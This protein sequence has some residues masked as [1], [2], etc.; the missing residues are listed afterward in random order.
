V[1]QKQQGYNAVTVRL[2]RGDVTAAQFRG[3]AKLAR[4][5]GDGM[6][7][8]TIDQNLL[9]RFVPDD[10]L[11]AL[12]QGLKDL[13]LAEPDAGTIVD[14]TSCPGAES[15]NLAVTASRELASALSAKLSAA[16]SEAAGSADAVAAAKDLHLKISGCPNSCGQHHVA[17]I[18]F[19]GSM[20]RVG[21]RV[22][23][24]YTL[25]L[26]GGID[27]NGAVF[28]RAFAKVPARRTPGALLKLLEL[29]LAERQPGEDALT[30][31]RRVPE[32]TVKGALADLS[33]IDEA[34]ATAE[35]Y[36]DLGDD[37]EFE[38]ATGPGECAT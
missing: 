11:E 29:Y 9:L 33:K 3:V 13:E 8:T 15:C 30:F 26:G 31:F 23:P 37:K 27:G 16:V 14:V 19:H 34:T 10:A 7:R 6:A 32:E 28:G 5:L 36:L 4:Q 21:G 35:D 17:G 12:H 1:P 18:G 2:L 38:V 25:H 24:E 22:V 20:R